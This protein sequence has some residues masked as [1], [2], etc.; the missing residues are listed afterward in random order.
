[1]GV[2]DSP[3]R[4][5][6]I[7]TF[8]THEGF[9]YELAKTGHAFDVVLPP[10]RG[11]QRPD[12]DERSRPLPPNVRLVGRFAE[13]A[14]PDPAGYDLAIAQTLEQFEL[15]EFL[16]VPK[17]LL[18]HTSVAAPPG[19][20]SRCAYLEHLNLARRLRGVPI[21]YV[22]PYC[23]Q[24]W[25][26]PGRVILHAV[27]PSDYAAYRW[28]GDVR[29]VLTVS[30]FL[31][32]R[33]EDTG[34][35]LHRRALAGIPH[36]IIGENPGLPDSGPAG[37]W[38]ELRRAYQRYGAYLDT[39]KSGG[40]LASVEAATAGMP[41]VKR[42]RFARPDVFTDGYD[43]FISAD[44]DRLRACALRLLDDPELARTMGERG[45]RT[46]AREWAIERFLARWQEALLDAVGATGAGASEPVIPDRDD[47]FRA[48]LTVEE[49]PE[50]IPAGELG[51]ARVRVRNAG[52]GVWL[53]YTRGHLARVA[54]AYRWLDR[55]GDLVAGEGFRSWLPADLEP[56]ASAC[57][58]ALF[59]APGTPGDHILRW[60]LVCEH[61]AWFSERGCRTADVAIE[62][63]DASR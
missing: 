14:M 37:S 22:S 26:L 52:R 32:E 46:A 10:S 43:A 44:P 47:F 3:G 38:D 54:L 24:G 21:V 31:R 16:P 20:P 55:R 2:T 6:R 49:A 45:R 63:A 42:P 17:L 35:A 27:D 40:A 62:V 51:W 19:F 50:R 7:L 39:A 41:L 5:L 8:N 61:V 56:G 34:Y 60:D 18:L 33:A 28:R 23:Q 53:A 25:G 4:P 48:E 58:P 9:N 36:K 12:W 30:H 59:R 15:V 11:L 29:A 13:V 1:L 57:I